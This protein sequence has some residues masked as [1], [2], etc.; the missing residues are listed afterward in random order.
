MSDL[1]DRQAVIKAITNATDKWDCSDDYMQ[2]IKVGIRMGTLFSVIPSAQP[3]THDKRTETHA[4]DLISRKAAI[5][6]ENSSNNI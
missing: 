6:D 5:D 1:I 2:G 4:C 3:E